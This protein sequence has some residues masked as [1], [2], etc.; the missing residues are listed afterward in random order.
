[1][2][3]K[4]PHCTYCTSYLYNKT[5]KHSLTVLFTVE[6]TTTAPQIIGEFHT[7]NFYQSH[8]RQILLIYNSR[9]TNQNLFQKY[10]WSRIIIY[11]YSIDKKLSI[12]LSPR[13]YVCECV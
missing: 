10:F 4:T 5:S 8:N 9:S 12:N 2:I 11:F 7:Q 6:T 1:M 3:E 13:R